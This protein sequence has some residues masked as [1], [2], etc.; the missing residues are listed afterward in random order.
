MVLMEKKARDNNQGTNNPLLFDAINARRSTFHTSD[1]AEDEWKDSPP[2]FVGTKTIQLH[3]VLLSKKPLRSWTETWMCSI[4]DVPPCKVTTCNGQSCFHLFHHQS[5]TLFDPCCVEAQGIQ[6]SKR[7]QGSRP[8]I[9]S[10]PVAGRGDDDDPSSGDDDDESSPERLATRR[11]TCSTIT[12]PV[13]RSRRS[14]L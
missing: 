6:V 4:C 2:T 14:R 8:A 3:L 12:V 11:R 9:P 5:E 1:H 10:S 13:R 7:Y